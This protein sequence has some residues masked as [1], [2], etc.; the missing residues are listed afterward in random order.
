MDWQ[1][2]PTEAAFREQVRTFVR[3]RFPAGYEPDYDSEFSLEPED[4]WGYNWVLDRDSNDARRR[5]GAR[6][7]ASALAEMGWIAPR[8]PVAYGGAGLSAASEFIL[9]EEMMRAGVPTVNGNGALLLGP[10]LLA[11][12]TEE[13]CAEH[14][15]QIARG[16]TVWAQAFS[17]PDAGSDLAG[18]RTRADRVGNDY[19]LNGQKIWTSLGQY[20]DWLFVVARTDPGAS[21]H[22]GISFL[23]VDTATE[24]LVIRPI[25][26]MRGAEPFAEVF[27]DDVRVPAKNLVGGENN[28]W[29]VAMTALGFER[30]GI[31]AVVKFE[32][33]VGALVAHVRDGDASTPRPPDRSRL[34]HDI[35]RRYV[36]V[37][38]LYNLARYTVFREGSGRATGYEASVNQLFGAELHQRLATT[39]LKALGPAGQV[40]EKAGSPPTALFSHLRLDSVATPFLGGTTEIQRNI[41]ATRGLGLPR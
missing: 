26:D 29:Y 28:G 33:A 11:H 38:V 8:W 1:D 37:R 32:Q 24:G 36:E 6:A 17:E 27:F 14:L 35:V 4:V 21:R 16:E 10:T 5:D 2:T 15:P 12:G 34:R 25:K 9:F 13:Q 30:A 3:E 31:G 20:A 40:R 41:I 7:W 22:K 18:I 39:A 23:L 19:L